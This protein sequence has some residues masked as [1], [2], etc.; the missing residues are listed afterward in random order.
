M[1]KASEDDDDDRTRES[2]RRA[3]RGGGE[4]GGGGRERDPAVDSRVGCSGVAVFLF[5]HAGGHLL[6]FL[7]ILIIFIQLIGIDIIIGI[8]L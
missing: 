2:G 1:L 8:R 4:E 7:P 3:P 5:V 6:S